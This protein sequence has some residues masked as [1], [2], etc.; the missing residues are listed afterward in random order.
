[1]AIA[2]AVVVFLLVRPEKGPL[3]LSLRF[4]HYTNDAAGTRTAMMEISNHTDTPYQWSLH[5]HSKALNHLVG[6][7]TLLQSNGEMQ[8]VSPYDGGNL[9][10]HDSLCFGTD[11][12]RPGE[13]F[14]VEIT[15]YPKTA[16]ELRRDKVSGW[17]WK[18]G[19]RRVAHSARLGRR[20]DG[21]ALPPD[22]R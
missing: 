9:F 6:V 12:F 17:L 10:G 7:T 22:T 8:H 21:A 13:Q 20:I 18:L 1:M 14:W 3:P 11:E 2:V 16:G 15:H 4:L 19:L 5:S